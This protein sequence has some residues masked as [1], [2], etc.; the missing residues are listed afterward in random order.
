L[1]GLLS[2]PGPYT[3]FAPTDQAFR[4]AGIAS[5]DAINNMTPAQVTALTGILANH[6]LAGTLGNKFTPELPDG[7]T[8]SAFSGNKLTF[9]TFNNGMLTVKYGDGSTSNRAVPA[10]M[11]IPDVQCTNGVVHVIDRVLLPQ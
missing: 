8:V 4:D 11:P 3:V 7:T 5:V 6:V 10:N 1:Q 2:Q 9:S